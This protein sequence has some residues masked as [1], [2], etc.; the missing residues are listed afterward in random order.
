MYN[1]FLFPHSV[2]FVVSKPKV[3]AYLSPLMVKDSVMNI[4]KSFHEDQLMVFG[5]LP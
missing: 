4:F 2:L 5:I 1:Y 3:S